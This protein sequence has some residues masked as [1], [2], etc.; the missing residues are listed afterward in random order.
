MA[1]D[2]GEKS[3]NDDKQPNEDEGDENV[4]DEEP[5]HKDDIDDVGLCIG[6]CLIFLCIISF[7]STVGSSLFQS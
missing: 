2:Y 1:E 6:C 5:D 3:D 7:L 4:E